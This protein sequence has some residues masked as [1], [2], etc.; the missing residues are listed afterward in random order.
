MNLKSASLLFVDVFDFCGTLAPSSERPFHLQ[1][2]TY[3][4]CRP[5]SFHVSKF[6][7]Q[8]AE[9][10][11]CCKRWI[12]LLIKVTSTFV[13]SVKYTLNSFFLIHACW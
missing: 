5:I 1:E 13:K 9:S 6:E 10:R 4:K 11:I 12:Y 2:V 7:S 8:L 3:L